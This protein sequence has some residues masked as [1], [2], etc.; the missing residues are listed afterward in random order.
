MKF[1]KYFV[2]GKDYILIKN[3]NDLTKT[4]D[5][6]RLCNR[7][8]G[9]GADAVAVPTK[10]ESETSRIKVW[11]AQSEEMKDHS[12]ASMCICSDT[13]SENDFTEYSFINSDNEI[14]TARRIPEK[15]NSF[16]CNLRASI[17]TEIFNTVSRRTEIG[18]RILTIT[19][20]HIL[21]NFAVHFSENKDKLNL[22]YLGRHI[23]E[24]SLFNKSVN[25]ILAEKNGINSYE[26]SYH[27]AKT[28]CSRPTVAGYAATA[29][30]ACKNGYCAYNDV[31]NISCNNYS[32]S[33]TCITE[34]EIRI[35]C[36]AKKTFEG[37]I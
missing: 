16:Y 3:K 9:I 36:E 22:S 35:E 29:L 30:A 20:I 24:N 14:I 11:P 4:T 17:P 6:K 34:E 37:T 13:I 10:I 18:N 25:L 19:P 12:S 28:V 31:I 23:S 1:T 33:V 32:V 21:G 15:V 5:I 26:I 8:E 27:E 7:T 2:A